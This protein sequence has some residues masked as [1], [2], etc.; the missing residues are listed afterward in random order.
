MIHFADSI[1]I[2]KLLNEPRN[3]FFFTDI[4]TR[5]VELE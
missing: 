5:N 4:I 3:Y 2:T 1:A